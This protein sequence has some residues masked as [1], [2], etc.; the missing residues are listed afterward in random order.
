VVLLVFLSLEGPLAQVSM[1]APIPSPVPAP[2]GYADAVS[3]LTDALTAINRGLPLAATNDSLTPARDLNRFL[4]VGGK[5]DS[6]D[7]MQPQARDILATIDSVFEILPSNILPT[8]LQTLRVRFEECPLE[9]LRLIIGFSDLTSTAFEKLLL[10]FAPGVPETKKPNVLDEILEP[11]FLLQVRDLPAISTSRS[12]PQSLSLAG[13]VTGWWDTFTPVGDGGIAN[14]QNPR[15]ASTYTLYITSY[16]VGWVY[17]VNFVGRAAMI[18]MSPSLL[19]DHDQKLIIVNALWFS[20]LILVACQYAYAAIAVALSTSATTICPSPRSLLNF[21]LA[22]LFLISFGLV[23]PNMSRVWIE[24]VTKYKK[25]VGPPMPGSSMSKVTAWEDV[26]V[27]FNTK[28]VQGVVVLLMDKPIALCGI[29]FLM[30]HL[31]SSVL[32]CTVSGKWK[33]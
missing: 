3:G 15:L 4:G 25:E 8:P 11:T 6:R 32:G 19:A 16:V 24:R 5:C 18:I 29:A 10:S 33:S 13:G 31:L 9:A 28:G 14:E 7:K 21:C 22:H 2:V 30:I 12:V 20:S 17:M 23:D 1:P 27:A 26:A